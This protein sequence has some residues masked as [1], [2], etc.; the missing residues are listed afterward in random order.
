MTGD[1]ST[2]TTRAHFG[3]TAIVKCPVPLPNSTTIEVLLG[4]LWVIW[5]DF[6]VSRHDDLC[7]LVMALDVEPQSA[8][9]VMRQ[10]QVLV[11]EELLNQVGRARKSGMSWSRIGSALGVTAQAVHHRSHGWSEEEP[12]HRQGSW[13]SMSEQQR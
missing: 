2:A 5:D 13:M 11:D 8:L 1:T 9:E 4:F 7:S 3:A 10:V 6:D 12:G